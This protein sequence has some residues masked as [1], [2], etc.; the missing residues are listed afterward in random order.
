MNQSNVV[1]EWAVLAHKGG[2]HRLEI[3]WQASLTD[4]MARHRN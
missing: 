2:L 4:G 1:V 3:I